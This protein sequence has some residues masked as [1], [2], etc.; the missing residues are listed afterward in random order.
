MPTSFKFFRACGLLVAC[1]LISAA[2]HA[3]AP[4]TIKRT[5]LLKQDSSIPGREAIMLTVELAPGAV[6]GRHTHAA[7]AFG[8]VLEGTPTLE[9]QGSST[10]T[11]HAGE[12]FFIPSGVV[13]QG[14]NLSQQPVRLAVVMVAEKGKPLTTP[15]P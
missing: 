10:L 9:K 4:P 12:A 13:H 14:L 5:V 1:L 3:D 6:E 8:F 15:A 2:L 11:L 7:D